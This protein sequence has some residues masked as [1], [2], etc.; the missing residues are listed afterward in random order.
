MRT[1]G[2]YRVGI[3]ADDLTSAADGAAPFVARGQRAMIGRRRMPPPDSMVV[4]ID[5]GSRS[6]SAR[7][8]ATRGA[9]RGGG[10]GARAR[11]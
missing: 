1:N 11:F 6:L 2:E 10:A 8:A 7:Q 3:L 5:S 9:R 4:A